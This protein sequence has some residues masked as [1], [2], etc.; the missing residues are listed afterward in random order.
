MGRGK[1]PRAAKSLLFDVNLFQDEINKKIRIYLSASI[2][3]NPM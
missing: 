3:A 2:A 1:T